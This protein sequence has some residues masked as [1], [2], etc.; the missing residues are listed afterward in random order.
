MDAPDREALLEIAARPERMVDDEPYASASPTRMSRV[1][2]AVVKHSEEFNLDGTEPS[3]TLPME[4]YIA[5]YIADLIH[6][7]DMVRPGQARDMLEHVTHFVSDS[8]TSVY[9]DL[10]GFTIQ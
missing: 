9:E 1:A 10:K 4:T 5:S 7:A 6:L 3:H 2:L 8:E